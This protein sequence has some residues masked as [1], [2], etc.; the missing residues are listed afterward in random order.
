MGGIGRDK[1]I[2]MGGVNHPFDLVEVGMSGILA[3]ALQEKSLKAFHPPVVHF[4]QSDLV[5][6]E[7]PQVFQGTP[8]RLVIHPR[9]PTM[10]HHVVEV[11]NEQGPSIVF[12]VEA[13][14]TLLDLQQAFRANR[15]DESHGLLVLAFDLRRLPR[16]DIEL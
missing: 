9:F 13:I 2:P 8:P 16:F 11:V 3:E 10:L 6:L 1:A 14:R 5:E 12:G 7:F 4:N 15:L